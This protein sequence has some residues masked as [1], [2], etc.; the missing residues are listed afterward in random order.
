MIINPARTTRHHLANQ[1]AAA[2]L[3]I[4]KR[5]TCSKLSSARQLRQYGRCITWPGRASAE[6][7][8]NAGSG[9]AQLRGLP[10]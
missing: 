5:S 9:R 3:L 8:Q 4:R 6:Q 1:A 7:R 10:V 2:Y